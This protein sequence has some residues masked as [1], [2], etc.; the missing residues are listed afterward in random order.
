MS[1]IETA[2]NTS[3]APS[4]DDVSP[5]NN[6]VIPFRPRASVED[7][8]CS[9]DNGINYDTSTNKSHIPQRLH[10]DFRSHFLFNEG[11]SKINQELMSYTYSLIMDALD[12]ELDSIGKSNLFDEWK[13]S[14]QTIVEE[15]QNP[16]SNHRKVLGALLSVT[17]HKDF[18]DFSHENLKV[19]MDTTYLLRQLRLSTKESKRVINNL[20]AIGN[21]MVIPLAPDHVE[22][23]DEIELDELMKHLL[24]ISG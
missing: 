2:E 11:L 14:L 3:S 19:L 10:K 12:P 18:G 17:R 23:T 9:D 7:T 24:E 5:R 1:F 20:M 16:S 6:N 8:W 13:D 4:S 21:D 22:M 15:V